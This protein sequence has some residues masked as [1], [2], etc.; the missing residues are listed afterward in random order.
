[1]AIGHEGKTKH[2]GYFDDEIE[3]AR[4]ADGAC[5]ELGI[6]P[7]NTRLLGPSAPEHSGDTGL[8]EG[9]TYVKRGLLLLLLQLLVLLLRPRA[10]AT[11]TTTTLLLP[12]LLRLPLPLPLPLP[13]LLLLLLLLSY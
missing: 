11:T 12:L 5:M 1:V 13:L 7:R 8:P 3:A 4:A 2:V 9:H 6:Q 10:A